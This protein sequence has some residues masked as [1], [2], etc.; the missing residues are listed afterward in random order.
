MYA[1]SGEIRRDVGDES[2]DVHCLRVS[3]SEQ[4]LDNVGGLSGRA[5]WRN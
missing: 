3:L 4:D 5:G 2:R 1:F